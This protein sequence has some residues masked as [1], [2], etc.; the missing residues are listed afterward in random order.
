[1]NDEL[2]TKL[3]A[4]GMTEEQ[5]GKLVVAGA[6]ADEDIA[7]LT[8]AEIAEYSGCPPITA[9]KVEK[10][11]KSVP[12]APVLVAADPSVASTEVPVGSA[13]TPAQ[14]S[15]FASVLGANESVV[16]ML[17]A[18]QLAN[19]SG[20]DMDL[21]MLGLSP[22]RMV[23]GYR[24]KVRDLFYLGM[25]QLQARLGTPIVIINEDGSVNKPLTVEY[26]EGLEEGRDPAEDGV[27][28]DNSGVAYQVIAVGVDAQSV[29]DADPLDSTRALQKSGL[30]AGRINWH[31]VS[32]EVKQ[33]AYYAV[34]TGEVDPKNESQM[35]I[36]RD[37]IKPGVSRLVWTGMAPKAISMFNQENRSGSLPTLRVMLNR[38]PR[39]RE[40]MSRRRTAVPRD[41]AGLGRDPSDL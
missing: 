19:G 27:Y 18:G 35:S 40:I 8:A 37:K 14:V 25:D 9:K 38:A 15:G 30:G 5:V 33:V 28:F 23:E 11:F 12:V 17:L 34:K 29:Y 4:L 6:S 21:S 24:P 1:M 36:I 13:P 20:L 39:R 3:I 2:K 16:G 41:L 10:G 26:V 31:G 22:A 32:L 7:L